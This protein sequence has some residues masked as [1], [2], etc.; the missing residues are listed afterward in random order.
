MAHFVQLWHGNMS[1][2]EFCCKYMRKWPSAVVTCY[3]RTLFVFV[4]LLFVFFFSQH[5]VLHCWLGNPWMN[6]FPGSFLA[7]GHSCPTK[8]LV[9]SLQSDWALVTHDTGSN[10]DRHCAIRVML[11]HQDVARWVTMVVF[12]FLSS[13]CV[14]E[15]R[16]LGSPRGRLPRVISPWSRSL[17]RTLNCSI[18]WNVS[19]HQPYDSV[20]G[21]NDQS[22]SALKA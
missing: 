9:L 7:L 2:S 15:R 5:P 12:M 14:L 17:I 3:M 13:R 6:M 20:F 21:W 8:P 1:V 18:A 16:H 4:C 19:S 10:A 11:A 22:S